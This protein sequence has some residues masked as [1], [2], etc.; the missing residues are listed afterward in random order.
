MTNRQLYIAYFHR[1]N[2]YA[3]RLFFMLPFLAACLGQST[4]QQSNIP[5]SSTQAPA[6]VCSSHSSNPITLTMYYGSEKQAWM[7]DMVAD[8]NNQ[9]VTACDGPITVKATP[10][11]SGQSMQQIVDGT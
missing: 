4:P 5:V 3:L 10:I 7:Q 11:G 6:L 8:F 2:V 9:H 1:I